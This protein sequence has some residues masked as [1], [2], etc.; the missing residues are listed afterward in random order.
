MHVIVNSI[1]RCRMRKVDKTDLPTNVLTGLVLPN[2][3]CTCSRL[4]RAARLL[5][6]VYD[7]SLQPLGLKL[8]QYS[9][10]INIV[11]SEGQTITTLAARLAMDRTT[12]TRNLKPLQRTGLVLVQ[13]GPDA[14]SR[15]VET[16][17]AGRRMLE[18]AI[19]YWRSAE[20]Q[21]RESLGHS[22]VVELHRLLDAAGLVSGQGDVDR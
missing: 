10:L 20:A 4:R 12:L 17:H 19:P 15:S 22:N 5:T 2:L 21:V 18:K 14:R 9:V 7:R 11:R 13:A 6:Q 8:T 1:D 16:T 3:P